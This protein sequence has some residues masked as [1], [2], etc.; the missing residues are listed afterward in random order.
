MYDQKKLEI[1]FSAWDKHLKDQSLPT[2][3]ELPDLELYMDQVLILINRY[4]NIFNTMGKAPAVTPPMINNYVKQK[5]IPAPV[6]KKYSRL[7]MA[8]L[9]MVCTLK[10]AL[11]IA[12]IE[13]LIPFGLP[14]EEVRMIYNSFVKNQKKAFSYVAEQVTHVAVPILSKENIDAER[15][16]DLVLQVAITANIFKTLSD[17]ISDLSPAVQTADA[18]EKSS[19]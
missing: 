1:E 4:N 11:N 8:Y 5:T 19:K 14:E 16:Q 13:K 10:Q 18:E 12:T 6:N 15:V 9:I 2:W 17:N 7:H 3:E